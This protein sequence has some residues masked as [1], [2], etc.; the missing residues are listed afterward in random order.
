MA[1]SRSPGMS[2]EQATGAD[3]RRRARRAVARHALTLL[4]GGNN[5][6]TRPGVHALGLPLDQV[7]LITLDAHFD[8]RD[9][10]RR[11]WAMAIRC[12]RCARMD[13]RAPT[14]PRSAWRRSP[15][16]RRCT[17]MRWPPGIWS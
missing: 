3:P 2:I 6:V 7:G 10:E 13:C 11:A 5:A 16:P 17:A 12:A 14:S 9:T 4:V 1:M 15:I 8:L